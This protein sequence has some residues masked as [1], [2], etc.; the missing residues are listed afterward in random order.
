MRRHTGQN[1][2]ESGPAVRRTGVAALQ[3]GRKEYT[4]GSDRPKVQYG[5]KQTARWCSEGLSWVYWGG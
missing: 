3:Q 2:L 4:D 5:V 1:G